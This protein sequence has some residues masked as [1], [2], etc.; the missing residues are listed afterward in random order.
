MSR[1]KKI[2]LIL[3]AVVPS[4]GLLHIW[5]ARTKT[6][7]KGYGKHL[8]QRQHGDQ[9]CHLSQTEFFGNRNTKHYPVKGQS[10]GTLGLKR[11]ESQWPLPPQRRPWSHKLVMTRETTTKERCLGVVSD[12]TRYLERYRSVN[13]RVCDQGSGREIVDDPITPTE[14]CGYLELLLKQPGE[15]KAPAS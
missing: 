2:L 13:L 15:A 9:C 12:G 7:P 5:G 6:R 8:S 3:E 10:D 1:A 11:S 14:G 4:K